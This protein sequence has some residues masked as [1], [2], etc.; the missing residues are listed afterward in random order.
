V[1]ALSP[2]EVK[3]LAKMSRLHIFL[4]WIILNSVIGYMMSQLITEKFLSKII[5]YI[6]YVIVGYQGWKLALMI[7]YWFW[8]GTVKLRIK[9][10]KS[11]RV[12][13]VYRE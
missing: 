7:L 11:Q 10:A 9:V 3:K 13:K 2:K 8:I 5:D 12:K 1:K 4:V 6:S